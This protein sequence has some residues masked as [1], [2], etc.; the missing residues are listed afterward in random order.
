MFALALPILALAWKAT[1]QDSDGY[2]PHAA[3]AFIRTGERTPT[4]RPGPPVLT[5]LGAQQMYQLGQKFRTRYIGGSNVQG[6][7]VQ[8]IEGLSTDILDNNQVLVHTL[9]TPYLVSS[10][11]AFMQ[12]L[13]PPHSIHNGSGDV[14][15]LLANGS[16]IEYP[17][18][19]YQYASIQ[20]MGTLDPQSIHLQ[21]DQNCPYALRD[22]MTWFTTDQS[23][24]SKTTSDELYS[25]INLD[26]SE[27]SLDEFNQ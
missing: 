7:G 22:A 6:F 3:F 10:S 17:L 11:Q 26:W 8:H 9:D 24:E 16:A 18:G 21:G 1:A 12:G 23:Q 27:A 19:G 13:Y 14:T 4:I 20:A 15:G 5:A 2:H 25:E